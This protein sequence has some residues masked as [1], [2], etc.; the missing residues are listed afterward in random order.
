M[1]LS[2]LKVI[3]LPELK[4]IQDAYTR[5]AS[6]INRTP[7]M[8]S[9]TL[10][11]LANA[12]IF[13]KCENFQ[14]GGAFK[15]RGACN[16]ILQLSKEEKEN[17]I[18]AH[19]SGNH[20]QAVSL[21]SSLLGVKA[22]IVMPNNAPGVKVAATKGYGAEIVFSGN[23]LDDRVIM[24]HE[25]ISQH[26]YTLIHPYD[27]ENVIAGAG[28]A[29]L[30]FLEDMK[31]K[32]GL[33]VVFCPIGGGGFISGTSTSVKGLSS[34]SQVIGV[35][36]EIANDAYRSFKSGKLLKNVNIGT[37]ADGLRTSLSERTFRIIQEN[38]DDIVTVSE[39]EIL[40][41]MRFLWER[42]KLVVEPSGAVPVAAILANKVDVEN[43][44]LGIMISGG[45]ID[46]DRF[47]ALLEKDISKA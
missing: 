43:R 15:F 32:G 9:R 40:K 31:G 17:G 45:N 7:I 8:T 33:D 24:V 37:I 4:D 30:E 35:E 41:A 26:K 18:I 27:N 38:V 3:I 2:N 10:N 21:A 20:A 36:P 5:I 28:T 1:V 39:T 29:A 19:S 46:L 47:F 16:A 42:M 13:L 14:R 44:Q 12:K 34:S 6:R 11:D 25:L 22:V 23:S